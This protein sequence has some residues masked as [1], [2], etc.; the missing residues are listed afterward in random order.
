M[1]LGAVQI[2]G[3]LAP[4]A[5]L[6]HLTKTLGLDVYGVVAYSQGIA[7]LMSVVLDLG[8]GLSA[9][10]KVSKL[11]SH[12]EYVSQLL[13]AVMLIKLALIVLVMFS[14]LLYALTTVKYQEYRLLFL[15]SVVPTALFGLIPIW[16]FQGVERMKYI[17]AFV[18]MEKVIY[19][20]LIYMFVRDTG[21]YLWVPI[22]AGFTQFVALVIS[23]V[24]VYRLG[25]WIQTP[26]KKF[27]A[28]CF[29]F[30]RHFFL[31]RLAVASYMSGATVI[32][33]LT[34][35]PAAVATY[36]MAEQLYKAMQSAVGPVAMAT[37]PYMSK[38]K[39]VFL[40]FKIT[41]ITVLT[42]LCCAVL[43]FFVSPF[44]IETIF[45][46]SWLQSIPVL[47]IFF[48]AIVVHTA[49]VMMGYPLAASVGKVGIANDSVITGSIIYLVLLI[50]FYLLGWI[51]P[52][53]LA[54]LMVIGE[55][56]VLFH[57]AYVLLPIAIH[58]HQFTLQRKPNL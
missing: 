11:R 50:A 38:E 23:L 34:S 17:A 20:F 21:D 30:T 5:V 26:S 35:Q 40:M 1:A 53:I 13:G 37:Y 31:S 57:R 29:K 18:V 7:G 3:Y 19:V 43:G 12:R 33:G 44:L 24:L 49:A 2:V 28:Y 46:R 10:N 4:F 47:N 51:S 14:I 42:V 55:L 52:E 32:L 6:I 48:I 56:C 22:T 39:N 36:S 54:L 16:L 9:T 41:A 25:F 58:Q 15:L 27:I 8:F 45:D